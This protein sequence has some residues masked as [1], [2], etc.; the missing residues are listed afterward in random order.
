MVRFDAPNLSAKFI[1]CK[2]KVALLNLTVV[3]FFAFECVGG[4]KVAR[5]NKNNPHFDFLNF[6]LFFVEQFLPL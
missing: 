5:F 2:I 6:F 1:K 4:E 3:Y